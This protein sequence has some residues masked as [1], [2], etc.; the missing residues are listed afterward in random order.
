MRD[1]AWDGY[2]FSKPD[3]AFVLAQLQY[4]L[5]Q[6]K[7]MRKY[8]GLALNIQAVSGVDQVFLQSYCRTITK[9]TRAFIQDL[10]T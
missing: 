10:N 5:A 3:S 9:Q 8:M 4:D 7:G 6:E 2:L 1:I